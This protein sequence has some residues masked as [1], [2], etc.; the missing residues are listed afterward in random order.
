VSLLQIAGGEDH[1]QG[2]ECFNVLALHGV[3][4]DMECQSAAP[5]RTQALLTIRLA[6]TPKNTINDDRGTMKRITDKAGAD[7]I[8]A[9]L[10]A[11]V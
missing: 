2:S 4:P 7:V 10:Q 3:R 6:P 1:E 8:S 11:F 5:G 9:Y